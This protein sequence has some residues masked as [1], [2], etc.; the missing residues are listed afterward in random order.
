MVLW[1]CKVNI[2]TIALFCVNILK[3]ICQTRKRTKTED[4]VYAIHL[5]FLG[6]SLRNASKALSRFVNRSHTAAIRDWIQKYQPEELLSKQKKID[7]YI[8]DKTLI[9]VGSEFIWLWVGCNWA[10]KQPNSRTIHLQREE[11]V[12]SRKVSR[13][14]SQDSWKTSSFDWWWRYL[15]SASMCVSQNWS[16]CSFSFR[17]KFDIKKDTVYQG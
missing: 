8:V 9:K 15:V 3:M 11:H 2:K 4:I 12:D 10:R 17:E 13:R 1:L 14:F 16:P 5:Y 6:L 7:E